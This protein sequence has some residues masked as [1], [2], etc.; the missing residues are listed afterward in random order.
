MAY[1][2]L[3]LMII[4]GSTLDSESTLPLKVCALSMA[5][6]LWWLARRELL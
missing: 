6:L 5:Y 1:I 4:S 2:A 3:V